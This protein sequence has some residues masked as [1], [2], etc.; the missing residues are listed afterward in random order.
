MVM[1]DRILS[2]A[3]DGTL[4]MLAADEKAFRMIAKVKV[5]GKNWCNPAYAGGK[6]FLRDAN[7][8]LC[9]QLVDDP[10][11]RPRLATWEQAMAA[12]LARAKAGDSAYIID[13]MLAPAFVDKLVA[14]YGK[15]NWKK[16]FHEDKLG[17]LGYYYGWLEN[18]RVKTSGDTTVVRGRHGC[19]AKFIKID[20]KYYVGD[21][22]QNLSSM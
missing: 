6:L 1:G 2:L 3:E 19:Y 5:C 4:F 18:G 15:Q 17:S 8:L 12:A 9:V 22:G 13:H 16:K 10:G 7:E 20:G 14:K 21:F 11:G